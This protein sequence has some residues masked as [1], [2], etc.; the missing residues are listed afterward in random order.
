MKKTLTINLGGMVY[1]I[2]EDAYTVLYDYLERIKNEINNI[3]GSNEIYDD[4]ENRIA[5]I[6]TTRLR[7]SR[8]IVTNQ[9]I[10][11]VIGMMGQP[12][13]ISGTDNSKKSNKR[14]KNYRRMYRDGDNRIIGGVCS[15]LA[16]Y[17]NLDPNIVRVV[18]VVL[19]IFGMAGVI[20]YL[21]LWIVLPEAQT[22]AQKIEM[23][24]EN[25][26]ISSI[27]DFFKDEF[28]NVKKNFQK[29]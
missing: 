29:K 6:L 17:W 25:V 14:S 23:R 20:I 1:H 7:S 8:Q 9:D 28:E 16:I 24:G 22:S 13:D 4:I 19:S 27:I 11:I 12:E 5:E 15:G 18:F 10:D 21:V 3:E 2:D 26:T